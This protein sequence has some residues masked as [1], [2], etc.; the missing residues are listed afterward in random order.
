MVEAWRAMALDEILLRPTQ[1]FGLRITIITILRTMDRQMADPTIYRKTIHKQIIQPLWE[2]VQEIRDEVGTKIGDIGDE[3]RDAAQMVASELVENA[4]KYG[5]TVNSESDVGIEFLLQVNDYEIIIKVTNCVE[6]E[7]DLV[8][9]KRH[10]D[11]VNATE[12]PQQLYIQRL[13]ELME[14]EGKGISQ[15]GLFRIAY[16][17]GFSLSYKIVDKDLTVKAYRRT[18]Y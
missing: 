6:S 5:L 16:E 11:A 18:K 14:N 13:S 15:L 12:D 3:Y 7:H 10:I 4:V 2:N 9:V 8:N 17:G 1:Y